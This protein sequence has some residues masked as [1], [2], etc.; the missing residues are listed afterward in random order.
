MNE[1]EPPS[2]QSVACRSVDA[3]WVEKGRFS[4]RTDRRRARPFSPPH[5]TTTLRHGSDACMFTTIAVAVGAVSCP[6]AGN[7][8]D[9]EQFRSCAMMSISRVATKGQPSKSRL[10][11]LAPSRV[12]SINSGR[13]DMLKGS[14]SP[15]FPATFC[16]FSLTTLDRRQNSQ[17]S[18]STVTTAWSTTPA[19]SQA[20]I[21]AH[22]CR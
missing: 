16:A 22:P 8:C 12:E 17:T 9:S 14:T 21:P 6:A 4:K 20:R 15:L 2:I 19:L 10:A 5:F 3:S 1:P 7:T 18:F 13:C 11:L